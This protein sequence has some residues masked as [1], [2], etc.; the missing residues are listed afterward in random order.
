MSEWPTA[1]STVLELRTYIRDLVEYAATQDRADGIDLDAEGDAD[2][3][4]HLGILSLDLARLEAQ[5]LI[6][7]ARAVLARVEAAM[8]ADVS[9]HGAVRLGDEG[10]YA[11]VESTRRL[12]DPSALV[13]WLYQT[14]GLA[15]VKAAVGVSERN[16]RVTAIRGIA[17]EHGFDPQTVMD[18]LFVESKG[19]R[20]LKSVP[21]SKAKWAADLRHSERRDRRREAA[22]E[23]TRIGL[24]VDD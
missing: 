19:G 2:V 22:D 1:E 21:V 6:R 23:V 8:L 16:I 4:D 5:R 12:N 9:E 18:S 7:A 15:A 10:F 13:D 11:G 17:A 14:G 24:T 3:L 20:V